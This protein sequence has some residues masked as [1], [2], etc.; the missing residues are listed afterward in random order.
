M[1]GPTSELGL[2]NFV[3]QPCRRCA[4]YQVIRNLD[5]PDIALSLPKGFRAIFPCWK[6]YQKDFAKTEL[7]EHVGPV[8][9]NKTYKSRVQLRHLI[10]TLDWSSF[11]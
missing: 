8:Y 9:G 5:D 2:G 1:G 11:L 7:D 10:P 6:L 4:S 3:G